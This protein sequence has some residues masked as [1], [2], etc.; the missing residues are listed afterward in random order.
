MRFLP[1][2]SVEGGAGEWLA[3]FRMYTKFGGPVQTSE[4][5]DQLSELL[6]SLSANRFLRPPGSTATQYV[7]MEG[8]RSSSEC[9]YHHRNFVN[10]AALL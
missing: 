7:V 10:G 6:P 1:W 9:E 4:I 2:I 5:Q 8:K 3:P